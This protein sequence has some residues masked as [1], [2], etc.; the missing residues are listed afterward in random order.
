MK[1]GFTIV[2]VSILFVI[3]LIVAILV[4]PLSLDDTIQAKN[5]SRWRNVQSDFSNIFYSLKTN[6]EDNNTDFT[7]AF[8][9]IMDNETKTNIPAYK[10]NSFG[11]V[12]VGEDYKF[13]NYKVTYS[14]A[15]FAYK[16]LSEPLDNGLKGYIMYD[17]NGSSKPNIW[18]KDVF[19]VNLYSDRFEPFC[20]AEPLKIQKEDCSKNGTGLC[21]SNYYL[22]GG[23]FD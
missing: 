16:M 14:N 19:G 1:R 20:K 13:E 7:T 12:P 5:T 8:Q 3:F 11:N 23:N 18:G 17:V 21:C 2:E 15:V 4:A 9:T 10:I 22:I 6:V